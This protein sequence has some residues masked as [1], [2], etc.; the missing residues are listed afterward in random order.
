M[1]EMPAT[2][3]SAASLK[4]VSSPLPPDVMAS[5]M[6]RTIF[7]A[8]SNL[9]ATSPNPSVGAV[10]A[11]AATGEIIASAVTARGGRPHAEVLAL[12]DAGARAR[13][14]IMFTTLE[15]CSHFGATPPCAHT[16]V[17]AGISLVVYGSRDPDMRVA[18]RG[19]SWLET[20]GV[21][22]IRGEFARDSDWIN[23]GH[24]LRVTER[25]PFVQIKLAVDANGRV[26]L[27]EG[28]PVWVTGEEARAQAHMLRARA[29]AILVGRRTIEADDPE[30]T[31]RLPG[32]ADRSPVRVVLAPHC[33]VPIEAR[34]FRSEHPPVWI[35]CG[36]S[37]KGAH[38][39]GR[40]GVRIFDIGASPGGV[41]NLKLAM[42]R[43]AAEGVTRLL[44]EG[45]PRTWRGFFEAG[46]A[47]EVVIMQA[48][49]WLPEEASMPALS[50]PDSP[51]PATGF[52]VRHPLP[53]GE[54]V[55][56]G[57]PSPLAGEGQGEGGYPP[58]SSGACGLDLVTASSAFALTERRKAGADAISTYRSTL[59]WQA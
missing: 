24:G 14:A 30:L 57:V 40:R 26:P 50:K 51:H 1:T 56:A 17:D 3:L 9:G 39:F 53:Q 42:M 31:C 13:G 28:K 33:N 59:H 44:V 5:L 34:I 4:G 7:L 32:L 41:L 22:A 43:L 25:R 52:A 2:S 15:P 8:E 21:P 46:L 19:L 45:G 36:D 58:H 35:V 29:D 12:R 47:D 10:V 37:S 38:L 23:L 6:R 20:H 27:G 16:I 49:T 48:A 11:D 18:G 54:R 55:S